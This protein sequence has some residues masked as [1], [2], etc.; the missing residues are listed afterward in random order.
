MKWYK[1]FFHPLFIG[2]VLSA[3][4]IFVFARIFSFQNFE[5]SHKSVLHPEEKIY[6]C[7]IDRDGNSERI[8]YNSYKDLFN[9]TLSLFDADSSLISYWS[10][11]DFPAKNS[12]IFFGDYNQNGIKEIFLFAQDQD[13]IFLYIINPND[14]KRFLVER[15]FITTLQNKKSD[16]RIS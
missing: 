6:F 1:Y 10:F 5:I 7:D 12:S 13:S 2:F 8:D 9:P 14:D 3:T 15:R 11:F 16:Y 4:A